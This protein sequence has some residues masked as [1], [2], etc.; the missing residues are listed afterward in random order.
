MDVA[1]VCAWLGLI[2]WLLAAGR[3]FG[4]FTTWLSSGGA[5]RSEHA[6]SRI[7]LPLVVGHMLIAVVGLVLWVGFLITGNR[8]IGWAAVAL[9]PLVAVLGV[10]MLLRWR[11]TFR[12]GRH[13]HPAEGVAA[14]NRSPEARIRSVNV[15]VHGVAALATVTFVVVAV[16]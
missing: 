16:L 15:V 12:A 2:A 14:A 8:G 4:M 9:L 5:N 3:G 13:H 7:P 10:I 1:G 6:V 11:R